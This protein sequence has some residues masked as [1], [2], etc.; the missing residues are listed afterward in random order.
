[1]N[2]TNDKT[3]KKSGFDYREFLRATLIVLMVALTVMFTWGLPQLCSWGT[4]NYP[5]VT[6]DQHIPL[7]TEF[8]W[9]YYLTFPLGIFTIYLLYYKNR[10]AMWDV[11]IAFMLSCFIS[12]IFYFVYP[13]EMIKP[14]LD[15]VS[16]SDK[17]T[18]MTWGASRPVCC[19]PSQHCFM[20]L[21]CIFASFYEKNTHWLVR[22]FTAVFGVLIICSTVFIKQHYI[23]DFVASLVIITPIFFTLRLVNKSVSN[24]KTTKQ[25]KT[26]S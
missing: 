10:R 19:L 17:L 23:L 4:P 20:A 18:I 13:T 8:V 7:I 15:P 2:K 6:L 14:A 21:S 12:M 1:M 9:V 25:E 22:I 24:K 16:I 3:L 11:V 26:N 5:S